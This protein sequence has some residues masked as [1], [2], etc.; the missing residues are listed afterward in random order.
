MWTHIESFTLQLKTTVIDFSAGRAWWGAL[1]DVPKLEDGVEEL[2][3]M[4]D[5]EEA[6][7]PAMLAVAAAIEK[8]GQA[9]AASLDRLEDSIRNMSDF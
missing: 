7:P 4:N 8:A 2:R 5:S 1:E 9:M 6:I 3:R